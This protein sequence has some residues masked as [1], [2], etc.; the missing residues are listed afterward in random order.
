MSL[1]SFPVIL[2]GLSV[3]SI[4]LA[5]MALCAWLNGE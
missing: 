4:V 3:L 5:G 1:V 2:T